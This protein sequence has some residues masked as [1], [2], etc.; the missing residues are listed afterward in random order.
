M[1]KTSRPSKNSKPSARDATRTLRDLQKVRLWCIHQESI[2]TGT[3]VLQNILIQGE[4]GKGKTWLAHWIADGIR[5]S[6]PNALVL[7][8]DEAGERW[9]PAHLRL[10]A[11]HCDC[12]IGVVSTAPGS[13]TSARMIK[14]GIRFHR[15]IN[16]QSNPVLFR[17]SD[18][19]ILIMSTRST[20]IHKTNT[21][22]SGIYCHHDGY[23]DGVGAV[24]EKHYTDPAKVAALIA[25]GNLSCL[26]SD[27]TARGDGRGL[28]GTE[29]YH[30]DCGDSWE[31]E[32][33]FEAAT[34]DEVKDWFSEAHN[35]YVYVFDGTQWFLNDR[36]LKDCPPGI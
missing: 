36:P 31:D 3:G 33:P 8:V 10:M 25:L 7:V 2:A 4:Q 1:P 26:G 30:R 15:L 21:G 29:A 12:I 18:A 20:L 9:K 34:L 24:L 22:W 14:A 28:G 6:H 13:P 23:R 19:K 16:I 17:P 5:R 35:G 11:R 27:I 32:R